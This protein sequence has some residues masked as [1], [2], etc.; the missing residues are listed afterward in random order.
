M[1]Q[2]SNIDSGNNFFPEARS[3]KE[4]SEYLKKTTVNR[5]N[6]AFT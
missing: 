2:A 4:T 1:A 6:C 3:K 5:T